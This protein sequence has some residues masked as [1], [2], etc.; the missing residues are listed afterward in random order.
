L[1]AGFF[2]PKNQYR[3]AIVVPSRNPGKAKKKI[4]PCGACLEVGIYDAAGFT[5][6]DGKPFTGNNVSVILHRQKKAA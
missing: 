1:E 4:V 2:R 6:A 5:T 3:F